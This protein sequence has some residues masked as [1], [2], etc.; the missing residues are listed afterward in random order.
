MEQWKKRKGVWQLLLVDDCPLW[1]STS[2]RNNRCVFHSAIK[3]CKK[4]IEVL[5]S[6]SYCYLS[7]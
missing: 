3:I 4:G 2:G 7:C 5:L 6:H 1:V